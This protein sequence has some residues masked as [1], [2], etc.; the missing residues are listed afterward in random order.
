MII[1]SHCHLDH[2]NLFNK[3][4]DVVVNAKK[5]EVKYLLSICTTLDSFEKIKL[6]INKYENVYGTFGI[7]P[8]EAKNFPEIDKNYILKQINC[9]NKIVGIGETGVNEMFIFTEQSGSG[10]LED[11]DEV[12][13]RAWC[14]GEG[15]ARIGFGEC[16]SVILPA[17]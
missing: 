13:M 11:G 3:L 4:D 16:R 9:F 1:D 2:S 12:V 10:I 5:N 15:K 8:H 17:Q 6:I 7:H 14:E